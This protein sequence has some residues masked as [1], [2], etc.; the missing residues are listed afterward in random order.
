MERLNIP[1][2]SGQGTTAMSSRYTQDQALNSSLS[3]MGALLLS[4]C[5]TAFHSELSS[6][7]DADL[8]TAGVNLA[9][10]D[11]PSALLVIPRS[12]YVRNSVISGTR[13]LLIQTL[14]YL[15]WAT[16]MA[17]MTSGTAFAELLGQNRQYGAGILGFSS[18]IIAACVAGTST[19]LLDFISN[20]VSAFRVTLWIGV[21]TE[22]Y[23]NRS[24]AAS[25]LQRNDDRSW[26]CVLLGIALHSVNEAISSFFLQVGT[27]FRAQDKGIER[28]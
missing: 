21:R 3:P 22:L 17:E 15:E 20:A 14:F 24:L 11:K 28:K 25:G 16:R 18:G 23:R 5:L 1:V 9:D 2:F 7:S 10:F 27:L 19:T 4:S 13:L 8:E 12:S 26:S 6:L